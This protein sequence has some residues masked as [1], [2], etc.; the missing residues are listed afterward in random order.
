MAKKIADGVAI[1]SVR[2]YMARL[3]GIFRKGIDWGYLRRS[4]TDITLHYPKG[5]TKKFNSLSPAKVRA[6][7]ECTPQKWR[8]LIGMAVW[9]GMRIG[10]ILAAKWGNMDWNAQQYHI[11]ETLTC[12]QTFTIPKTK[13][14]VAPV[15]VSP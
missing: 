8:V 7:L 5:D 12:S 3:K 11:R 4:P 15:F 13:E 10:E 6:L 2:A 9:T 14:S 1:A